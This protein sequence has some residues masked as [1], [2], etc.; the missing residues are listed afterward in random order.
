MKKIIFFVFVLA[1]AIQ[2]IDAQNPSQRKRETP[3][4]RNHHENLR[5]LNL[6]EEQKAKFKALH[7]DFREQMKTLKK[8][9]D[10]TVKEW[11]GK[12]VT[13]RKDH[14]SKIQSVLTNEQKSQLE[15][16][17]SQ[18]TAIRKVDQEARIE[19]MKIRLGL[20]ND[21]ATRLKNKRTEMSAGMKA[22]HENKS[23]APEEK[24]MQLKEL[25]KKHQQSLETILTQDQMKKLHEKQTHRRAKQPV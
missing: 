14:R 12:A 5:D 13:L 16:T 15:K 17:R 3:R 10:I 23:L 6:S 21:Q 20:S 19:K 24:R 4:K 9:E 1:V 25:R 7:N 11:K 8:N 22:I 18:R 2:D